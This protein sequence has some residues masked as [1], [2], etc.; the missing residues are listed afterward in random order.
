MRFW[1]KVWGVQE[2]GDLFE[3]K[4]PEVSISFWFLTI[5]Y[6]KAPKRQP[7]P[8]KNGKTARPSGSISHPMQL[9]EVSLLLLPG[10]SS[11]GRRKD[12]RLF[13]FRCCFQKGVLNGVKRCFLMFI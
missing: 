11:H 4:D 12:H 1:G 5:L 8:N 3:E 10:D 13:V 2:K 9:R 6:P 7:T